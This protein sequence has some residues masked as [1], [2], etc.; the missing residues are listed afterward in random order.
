MLLNPRVILDLFQGVALVRIK[1]ENVLDEVAHF[2]G[3]MVGEFQIYILNTLVSLIVVVGFKG[4]E[5]ATKLKAENAQAPNVYSA[6][7]G[8]LHNHF[9][10]EVIQGAAQG[11]SAIVRR[12]NTPTE[13]CNLDGPLCLNIYK[14]VSLTK[15]L[16][17]FSG[18]IS[19]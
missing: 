13:I 7:V 14:I 3:E 2:R 5:T 18:L 10:R 19:L 16:R 9:R 1:C 12:M 6:V 4:R 15:Q 8:L 17:R 11:L